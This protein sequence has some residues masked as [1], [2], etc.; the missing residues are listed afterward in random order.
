M[1][2]RHEGLGGCFPELWA[3]PLLLWELS[4]SVTF[5]CLSLYIFPHGK[6]VKREVRTQG[7]WTPWAP[8]NVIRQIFNHP[9][10]LLSKPWERPK[11]DKGSVL[12][13]ANVLTWSLFWGRLERWWVQRMTEEDV[14]S[15]VKWPSWSKSYTRIW[16]ATTQGLQ[17]SLPLCLGWQPLMLSSPG[18][19]AKK[20]LFVSTSPSLASW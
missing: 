16:E 6:I 18:H 5:P 13:L 10:Q 11:L 15:W 9:A 1:F 7:M 12:P 17:P 8:K 19:L 4:T 14:L 20:S 3:C 2:L